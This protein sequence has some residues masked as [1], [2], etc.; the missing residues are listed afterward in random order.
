M[1]HKQTIKIP[2]KSENDRMSASHIEPCASCWQ[3]QLSEG[4][5]SLYGAPQVHNS[6]PQAQ[7]GKDLDEKV[8]TPKTLLK[9][10]DN[11]FQNSS[12]H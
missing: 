6:S 1:V 5:S 4:F 12:F 10:F 3:K 2:S 7:T 8:Q 11:I 9:Y